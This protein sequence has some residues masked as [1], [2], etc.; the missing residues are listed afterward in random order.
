MGTDFLDLSLDEQ[1]SACVRLKAGIVS[2]DEL[3]M[4]GGRRV[5]LNYGHTLAHAL[6]AVGFDGRSGVD[7]RH[8]EAVAI[9]LVFAAE[10]AGR[11]G[12][13]GGDGI[14]Q[15]RRIVKGFGL[16]TGIPDG[17]RADDLVAFMRRDKKVSDGM[18]FVLD[19][20]S[21]LERVQGID[22]PLVRDV[23]VA[24]GARP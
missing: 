19:G 8:G 14:D 4:P 5:L 17:V 1:V 21:G 20:A 3:E 24:T 13:I 12:R 18:V 9:G 7:L 16:P 6:E 11:L 2:E 23:L 10:L 15:H 22:E